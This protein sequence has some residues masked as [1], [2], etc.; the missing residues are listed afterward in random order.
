M[1]IIVPRRLSRWLL[2]PVL[3]ALANAQAERQHGRFQLYNSCAPVGVSVAALPGGSPL[4]DLSLPQL[5]AMVQ[6]RL[7]A[8]GLYD[9]EAATHL[10]ISVSRYAVHLSYMKPVIDVASNEQETIATFSRT[11]AVTEGQAASTML[12][13]SKLLNVFLS[14]YRQ[15]NLLDCGESDDPGP[16]RLRRAVRPPPKGVPQSSPPPQGGG[17][18][19]FGRSWPVPENERTVHRAGNEVTPPR[20]LSKVEPDY[21]DEAKRLGIEGLVILSLEIWQ[22]G[23]PHN[24]RV[25]KSLGHGL[26]EKAIEAVEQWRF[27]PGTNGGEAVRV[28]VQIEVGFRLIKDPVR[29]R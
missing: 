1:R 25:S 14:S 26:D 29:R 17:G 28:Q 7:V 16:P 8:D 11:A 2:V 4:I 5:E 18:I 10:R 12:E 24:I 19:T 3:A 13:L 15:V 22:D 20:L 23:R 6:D 27:S 9:G 21:S